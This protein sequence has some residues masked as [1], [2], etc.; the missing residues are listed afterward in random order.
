MRNVRILTL[1]SGGITW[2]PT[3]PWAYWPSHVVCAFER[4]DAQLGRYRL[5]VIDTNGLWWGDDVAAACAHF[6][7]IYGTTYTPVVT[8]W[9]F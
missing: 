6:G 9:P 4:W 3:F 1:V 8:P 2:Q 5:G 7:Q